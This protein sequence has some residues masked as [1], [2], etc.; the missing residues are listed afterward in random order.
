MHSFYSSV[1]LL[2][3]KING[4]C[5]DGFIDLLVFWRIVINLYKEQLNLKNIFINIELITLDLFSLLTKVSVII[6]KMF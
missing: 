1:H 6:Y 4:I 2:P 5:G 3:F